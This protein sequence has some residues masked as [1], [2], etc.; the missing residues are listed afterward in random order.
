LLIAKGKSFDGISLT[1]LTSYLRVACKR[2]AFEGYA[3]IPQAGSLTS[4][5]RSPCHSQDRS[6]LCLSLAA[7]LAGS[8]VS[9]ARTSDFTLH[10]LPDRLYPSLVNVL[11][12]APLTAF[13]STF[14]CRWLSRCGARSTACYFY[15][16][17]SYPLY[18][19]PD[20]S[21]LSPVDGLSAVPLIALVSF[22]CRW[23]TRHAARYI[24]YF[25]HLLTSGPSCRSPAPSFLPLAR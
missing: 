25:F 3:A 19:S 14:R 13:L 24:A 8:F 18:H 9:S 23:L 21:F 10:R 15:S 1:L 6:S 12:I 5:T 22:S 7:P 17:T 11:P 4:F 2:L 16:S 20:L